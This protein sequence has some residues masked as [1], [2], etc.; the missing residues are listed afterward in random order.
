MLQ[1]AIRRNASRR[2]GWGRFGEAAPLSR[3]SYAVLGMTFVAMGLVLI[4]APEISTPSLAFL[5][6]CFVAVGIAGIRDARID[7]R[8]K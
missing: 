8:S 7:K 3:A 5:A 4:H 2:W 6:V 1:K